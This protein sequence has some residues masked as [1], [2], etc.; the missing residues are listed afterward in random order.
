MPAENPAQGILQSILVE[1]TPEL[2][3][4]GEIVSNTI[5]LHLLQEPD[6]LLGIRERNC[7][8]NSY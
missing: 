1:F 8:A 7:F 6:S 2:K 5:R 4:T 3:G